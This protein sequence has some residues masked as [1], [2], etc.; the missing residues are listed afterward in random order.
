M[1]ALTG[2]AL[3][4]GDQARL[5]QFARLFAEAFGVDYHACARFI[6]NGVEGQ[7]AVSLD[8]EPVQWESVAAPTVRVEFFTLTGAAPTIS[9]R[10]MAA[11]AGRPI[12]TI[13]LQVGYDAVL[14]AVGDLEAT[15][16]VKM[17]LNGHRTNPE[18]FLLKVGATT[19][20]PWGRA[21]SQAH[22]FG[23]ETLAAL[24]AGVSI[25]IAIV[26]D[27]TPD[28]TPTIER[29]RSNQAM[30]DR[31]FGEGLQGF[32]EFAAEVAQ[33]V[34]IDNVATFVEGSASGGSASSGLKALKTTAASSIQASSGYVMAA[35]G[36]ALQGVQSSNLGSQISSAIGTKTATRRGSTYGGDRRSDTKIAVRR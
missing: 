29:G 2:S 13:E 21:G 20:I 1:K 10:V 32:A 3:S 16:L 34:S 8:P 28:P 25:R 6:L 36:A 12:D 33:Q 27:T 4:A 15:P 5:N 30:H 31:D 18:E 35:T 14:G 11:F 22:T 23:F 7:M 9:A 24:P 19:K 26:G 17:T